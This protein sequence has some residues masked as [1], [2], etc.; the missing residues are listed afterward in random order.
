[1]ELALDEANRR[2]E[3]EQLF[4]RQVIAV[5]GGL[6]RSAKRTFHDGSVGKGVNGDKR[7]SRC[8]TDHEQEHGHEHEAFA[9]A[10]ELPLSCGT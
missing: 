9:G 2:L 6:L 7:D 10:L 1:M 5:I 4:N 3:S 8:E